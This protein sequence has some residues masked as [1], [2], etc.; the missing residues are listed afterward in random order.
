LTMRRDQ[1]KW[2]EKAYGK[3][4]RLRATATA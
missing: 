2:L 4:I 1:C 3:E